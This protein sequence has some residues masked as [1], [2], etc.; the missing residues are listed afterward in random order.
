MHNDWKRESTCPNFT[1]YAT[2]DHEAEV[3]LPPQTHPIRIRPA[4]TG[5]FNE[6]RTHFA[7]YTHKIGLD[8]GT[9]GQVTQPGITTWYKR[10]DSS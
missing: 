8:E 7:A 9:T 2:P 3:A 6:T 10:T 1:M 5:K 4:H